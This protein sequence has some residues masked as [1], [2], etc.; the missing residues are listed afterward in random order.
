MKILR[1]VLMAALVLG[2][3]GVA[4]A[5]QFSVLDPSGPQPTFPPLN[6]NGPNPFT[7]YDCEVVSGDGC[8]GFVNNTSFFITSFQATI[9]FTGSIS[10][11]DPE[12]PTTGQGPLYPSAFSIVDT[13]SLS[14]NTI[15]VALS[16]TP[17]IAPGT[18]IW[19]VETGIPDDQFPENA[20][21]FT[22]TAAPTPEPSSIWMALTGISSLGYAVRRRRKS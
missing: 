14:G 8:F 5:F 12:C 19:I 18:L 1:Y 3:S 16:G 20:G 10:D 22:V 6:V 15:N 13:C 4:N 11:P 9:T 21:N 17:G 2:I 7:F